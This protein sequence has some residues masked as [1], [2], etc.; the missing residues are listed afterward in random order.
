M[1]EYTQRQ[2]GGYSFA[3][4]E[5]NKSADIIYHKDKQTLEAY[6]WVFQHYPNPT[7]IFEVGLK[8]GGSLVLWKEQFPECKVS[9]IEIDCRQISDAAKKVLSDSG[10]VYLD[11]DVQDSNKLLSFCKS[12][13]DIDLIIDDGQHNLETLRASFK[14]L[15]PILKSG[16]LFIIEDWQSL[17]TTHRIMYLQELIDFMI[18]Y[19]VD[20]ESGKDKPYVIHLIRNMIVIQ[21][22]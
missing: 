9:G 14:S 1:F 5:L 19:W 20:K 10:I 2:I 22:K 7:S 17:H 11:G 18:E 15:Y 8:N 16:G 12:L 6:Q 21:K 4:Y 3:P 13:G